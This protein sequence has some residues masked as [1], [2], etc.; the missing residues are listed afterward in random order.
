MNEWERRIWMLNEK[1][2]Y[3]DY[4]LYIMKHSVYATYCTASNAFKPVDNHTG[5]FEVVY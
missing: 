5:L 1:P 4:Y 3:L 2:E